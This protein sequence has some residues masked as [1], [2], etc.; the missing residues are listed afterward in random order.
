MAQPTFS[1]I[2][3]TWNAIHHLQ[4][5]LPS[6]TETNYPHFEI[7]VADNASNDETRSWIKKQYPNCKVVTFDKNYGYAGGNNKAVKYA[8]GD[9][10]VFLNNDAKPDKNWLHHLKTSFDNP[11]VSIVQP[12]ILSVESPEKFEYAGA[13]GGYIDKLGYPFCR[14]RIFDTVEE[15]HGQYDTPENIFWASGAALAIRKDLFISMGGFDED[16]EFHMEEIDLCWRSLRKGHQ[17]VFQPKSVVF[18]LGGGSLPVHS[19]RKVFYNY[20]NSL[21]MLLKN[22]QSNVFFLL[23]FRLLLDGVSGLRLLMKGRLR[24]ALAIIKAH[25]SFYKRI[26]NTLKKRDLRT[27]DL[28]KEELPVYQNLIIVDYFIRNIKTF[29]D[30]SIRYS[31]KRK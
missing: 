26:P 11:S 13:A 1:I 8:N 17:I 10:L 12:K 16:F 25:F 6:V 29:N 24:E 4:R 5:F 3:V 31:E 30:L 23:V 15:D 7:I 27:S 2:I 20:R 28:L 22:L 9:I 21:L 18:H 14:G 19:P